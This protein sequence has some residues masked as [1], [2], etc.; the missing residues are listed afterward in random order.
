MFNFY[1]F[2]SQFSNEVNIGEL[3]IFITLARDNVLIFVMSAD[4][5]HFFKMKNWKLRNIK[6]F[7]LAFL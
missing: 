3:N 6:D 2:I 7:S 5:L 4:A 1:N